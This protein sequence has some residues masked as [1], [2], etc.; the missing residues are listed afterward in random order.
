M[1]KNVWSEPSGAGLGLRVAT[2][3][4]LVYVVWGTTY[5]AIGVAL[6]EISP[7]WLNASRF[8][9]AGVLML[10]WA[11]ARGERLPGPRLL[12]HAAIVGGFMVS[13]AM[14]FVVF[15]QRAGIGSG[16]MATVVTTMPLWL[17]LWS[18]IGGA[19]V[20]RRTWT[21]L[22]LGVL[23]A[24]LLALERD[25]SATPLGAL[26]AFGAPLAWSLGSHASRRLEQP[27][28]GVGAAVQWLVGGLV[29][30]GM[31]L[32]FEPVPDPAH[33]SLETLSA[34]LYLLLLGTLVT[35]NAYL[36][37]LQHTS[38]AL[39]GSYSFVN[40]AVA[41]LLGA[42][43]GGEHLD[44]WVMLALPLILLALVL[45][46]LPARNRSPAASA[47]LRPAR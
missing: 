17:T 10:L 1:A 41:L 24:V 23:G 7:L 15:A 26:L 44:G 4:A 14:N 27:T 35:L 18:R 8:T 47:L 40:P 16:L 12:A 43:I 2:A 11:L 3:L 6:K 38:A 36:W 46:L 28:P 34:W 31:A 9:V 39:A 13:L 21:G 30:A 29:C 45:I 25:F 20:S 19:P 42:L 37:L 22:V 33:W 5:F 32:A